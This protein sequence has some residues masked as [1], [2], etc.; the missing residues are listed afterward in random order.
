MNHHLLEAKLIEDLD[1]RTPFAALWLFTW[2][3]ESVQPVFDI[4]ITVSMS[5]KVTMRPNTFLRIPYQKK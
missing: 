4:Q 5:G 2:K 1:D 3:H